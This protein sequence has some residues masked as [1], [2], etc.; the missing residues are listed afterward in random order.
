MSKF[1]ALGCIISSISLVF[2]GQ[3]EYALVEK[4]I[5]CGRKYS[6]TC[7]WLGLASEVERL[8]TTGEE[9]NNSISM[10]NKMVPSNSS[11][12]NIN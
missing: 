2:I 3:R 4:Q 5:K 6:W 12:L 1:V 8:L 7:W 10:K 11:I 9:R